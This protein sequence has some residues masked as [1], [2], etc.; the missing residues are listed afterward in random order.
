MM[1]I[2]ARDNSDKM[3]VV[4]SPLLALMMTEISEARHKPISFSAGRNARKKLPPL[5][6]SLRGEKMQLGDAG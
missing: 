1:M 2:N 5:I 4:I 6:L 3:V